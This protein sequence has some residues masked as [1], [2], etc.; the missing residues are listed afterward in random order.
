MDGEKAP[1]GHEKYDPS[2]KLVKEAQSL[3]GIPVLD[4]QPGAQYA[5]RVGRNCN[6]NAGQSKNGSPQEGLLQEVAIE[7][8]EREQA[9]QGA[10]A[11]TSLCHLQLHG[12]KLDDVALPQNRYAE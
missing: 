5:H 8:L 6:R 2:G 10:D 12:G 9:H 4:A 3:I 1:Q 11:A 7:D